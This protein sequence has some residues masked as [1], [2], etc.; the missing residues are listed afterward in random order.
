[1]SLKLALEQLGFAKCY[2][3]AEVLMDPGRAALWV[4]AAD[5][6]ADWD[7]IFDGY[8]ATVDYPGCYFWRQLADFCPDAKV[9]LSTRDPG[10]WFDSTQAS[11]FSDANIARS[12]D[13]PIS[14][15]FKK[16][17]FGEFG[18]HIHDRAFMTDYFR[19]WNAEVEAAV[20]ADRL[21]VYEVKQ[22][23]EPLCAFLGVEAP[24]TPFPRTNTREDFAAMLAEAETGHAP[25]AV[26]EK[27]TQRRD[28]Q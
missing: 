3:M 22:G 4:D 1:M 24:D 15:F 7:A 9:L 19:K 5:G 21:L 20:P 11:I 27:L 26:R 28:E 17:V 10:S 16:T 8:R 18:D 12:M 13:S 14:D 25:D 2:H 6:K 23:W